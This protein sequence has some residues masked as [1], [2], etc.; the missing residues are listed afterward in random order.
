MQRQRAVRNPRKYISQAEPKNKVHHIWKLAKHLHLHKFGYVPSDPIAMRIAAT[1]RVGQYLTTVK[2]ISHADAIKVIQMSL[3][4]LLDKVPAV[5]TGNVTTDA[6][7]RNGLVGGAIM[8]PA[9]KTS[10]QDLK[11]P[12]RYM[13]IKTAKTL[14][15]KIWNLGGKLNLK[16][17]G[18]NPMGAY[19]SRTEALSKAV[20]S[21]ICKE[22]VTPVV[23][24]KIVQ[25]AVWCLRHK[26]K[27]PSH[28][29]DNVT[30]DVNRRSSFFGQ[31]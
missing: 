21:V 5:Y 1:K 13:P 24:Q 10:W 16:Q 23:A 20:V 2:N 25:H 31:I 11:R 3:M 6:N 4:R 14:Q 22:R 9:T 12:R 7:R 18:Y 26:Y 29:H 17:F 19:P 8:S 27:W 15:Q 28:Q 30:L